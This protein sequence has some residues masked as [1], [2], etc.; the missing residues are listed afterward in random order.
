MGS[1]HSRRKTRQNIG[2][3]RVLPGAIIMIN[4]LS[5]FM[6]IHG[7]AS[8]VGF[9]DRRSEAEPNLCSEVNSLTSHP[10]PFL[11]TLEVVTLNMKVVLV[12]TLLILPGH[13]ILGKRILPVPGHVFSL[14]FSAHFYHLF[15]RTPFMTHDS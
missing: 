14:P 6:A 12:F 4:V 10:S 2:V 11:G 3:C 8:P 5:A 13:L 15:L 7:P 9:S 1:K